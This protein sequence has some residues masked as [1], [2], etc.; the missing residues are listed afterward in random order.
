VQKEK[1]TS[2]IPDVPG[3]GNKLVAVEYATIEDKKLRGSLR[4]AGFIE[5]QVGGA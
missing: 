2:G 4:D 3:G 5:A 1:E